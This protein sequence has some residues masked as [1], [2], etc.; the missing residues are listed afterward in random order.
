MKHFLNLLDFSK[1]ELTQ[2]LNSAD[3]LK[4]ELK[5]GMEHKLLAG[6]TLGMIFSENSTRTRVSF[7]TGIYQLGGH[8]LFLNADDLQLGRGEPINDTARTLSRYLDAIMIRTQNHNEIQHLAEF[9]NVPVI[10]GKSEFSHPCQALGDLMTIREYKTS[11]KGLSICIL[12]TVS[13]VFNSLLVGCVK[14]GI[15]VNLVCMS[16][17]THVSPVWDYALGS[18]FVKI[19]DNPR[20]AIEGVDVVYSNVWSEEDSDIDKIQLDHSLLSSAA[21]DCIVLHCLP[22]HKDKEI[23][24]D[25]FEEHQTEIFDQC[26]NRLHAQKAILSYLLS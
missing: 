25:V 18:D 20:D 14:M 11:F 17:S 3:Q 2:L 10:N 23:T 7:E 13:P 26:E 6:K 5:N 1:E 19:F 8:A 24:L 15:K 9:S 16:K 21:Q 22:A 12:G 4:Y